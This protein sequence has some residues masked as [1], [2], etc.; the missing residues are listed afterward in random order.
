MPKGFSATV[1]FAAC[2]T[3]F[4]SPVV[5]HLAMAPAP[6]EA[7]P[8]PRPACEELCAAD[9]GMD[10]D[11]TDCMTECAVYTDIQ[12]EE[13]GMQDF[14]ED[15]TYNED[16]GE[17]MEQVFNDNLAGEVWGEEKV[18]NCSPKITESP[19]FEEVDSNGDGVIDE[20]ESVRVG[21]KMCVPDE[22][23]TQLFLDADKN[24][25]KKL[26]KEEFESVGEDTQVEEAID[27][28]LQNETQG[29]DEFNPVQSPTDEDGD[30]VIDVFDDN[31]DGTLDQNEFQDAAEF[32]LHRRGM[33]A[34]Q[35]ETALQNSEEHIQDA[36]EEIDRNHD[37][38]LSSEEYG[39]EGEGNDMGDEL[40]Q[41]QDSDEIAEDPDDLS[42]AGGPAAA[43]PAAAPAPAAM[44]S[45]H[46]L[47]S[48]S[49]AHRRPARSVHH[50][51][52]AKRFAMVAKTAG[53]ISRA[54]HLM[55]KK[56]NL[57]AAPTQSDQYMAM[58]HAATQS[59]TPHRRLRHGRK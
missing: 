23:V 54:R 34:E 49:A 55:A 40:E 28:A 52:F 26:T 37:N 21:H 25:D 29:D 33:D 31:Q 14:V 44:I 4:S 43:A 32:E 16:G 1:L 7:E 53:R 46:R 41:A 24:Q 2:A 51:G 36:F 19:T 9:K 6:A 56:R 10:A 12:E 58:H 5:C 27:G 18:G 59:H 20:D 8:D 30:K 42:R 38:K 39:Q 22:M 15:E 35:S 3:F 11:P 13:E 50:P 17:K 48:R 47:K 45:V 57:A